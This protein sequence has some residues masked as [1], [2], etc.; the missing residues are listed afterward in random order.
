MAFEDYIS[1]YLLDIIEQANQ[2]HS[3]LVE[4]RDEESRKHMRGL[5]ADASLHIMNVE[6]KQSGWDRSKTMREEAEKVLWGMLLRPAWT[7]VQVPKRPFI[8]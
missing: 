8:L 4:L 7:S 6:T 5:I 1:G 3:A 2:S